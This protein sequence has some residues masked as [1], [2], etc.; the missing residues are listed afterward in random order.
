MYS[1]KKYKKDDLKL[2]NKNEDEVSLAKVDNDAK[3]N[4]KITSCLEIQFKNMLNLLLYVCIFALALCLLW[5]I[6][7]QDF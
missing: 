6:I 2:I 3:F 7:F 1:R 5:V 4:I